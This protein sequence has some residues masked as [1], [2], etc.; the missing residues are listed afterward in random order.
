MQQHRWRTDVTPHLL[1]LPCIRRS[2]LPTI[3][4]L[5]PTASASLVPFYVIGNDGGWFPQLQAPMTTL[6]MGPSERYDVII[7]FSGMSSC[8]AVLCCVSSS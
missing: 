4:P 6:Q 7:D 3:N 1:H 8:C 5:S 2:D